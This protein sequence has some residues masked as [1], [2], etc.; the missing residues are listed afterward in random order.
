MAVIDLSSPELWSQKYLPA[1]VEPKTYNILWG[2][3]G[4]GKSQTM[5]QLLLAE[6]CNHSLNSHIIFAAL[7]AF[8]VRKVNCGYAYGF[9]VRLLTDC[10]E[11]E[12]VVDFIQFSRLTPNRER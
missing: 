6:I 11:H 5:I 4:S 12:A 8:L 7:I 2:G 10:A 3:A 9:N 1:L